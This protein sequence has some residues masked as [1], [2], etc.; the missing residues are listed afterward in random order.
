MPSC[1]RV[2]LHADD[3]G[4]SP[5]VSEGIR[6]GFE[7]GLLTSTSVLSNAPD[8][9]RALGAWKS[10]AE[11]R[12]GG[13]LPSSPRRRRLDDPGQ[14]FDLGVHLNLTQGRPLSGDRFPEELLD[15]AGRLPGIGR[16][17]RRL[18][19][20]GRRFAKAVEDELRR[21]IEFVLDHGRQPAHLNG[22]EY[23]ELLPAVGP[24]VASLAAHFRIPAVRVAAETAWLG[25]LVR[26]GV[27]PRR[28]LIGGVKRSLARPLRRRLAA[29]GVHWPDAFFGGMSA[30]RVNLR[31]VRSFLA[32]AKR[33]RLVEIVLHPGQ[34]PAPGPLLP[35]GW[36]D[37]WADRRPE[38]L[39]LVLSD[40]L[41]DVLDQAG[42]RLG[43]MA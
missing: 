25:S 20:A 3:Y 11:A 22:H 10:L 17:A 33:A 13:G 34:S 18:W 21:Q 23:V 14:D 4:L 1:R 29:A 2:I 39:R 27:A 41:A 36:C 31:Q 19:T 16:L 40:E 9:A 24:I 30:G 43:R 8:A 37:A 28:W 26:C 12:R 38:E 7:R 6:A 35:D 5:A 32:A 15:T 42:C